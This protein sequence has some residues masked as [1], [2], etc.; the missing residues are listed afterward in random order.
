MRRA[1]PVWLV[2]IM[3]ATAAGANFCARDNVPSATLLFPFIAV[4]LDVAG[5]PDSTGETTISRVTNASHQA[6]V[7]HVTV[8]DVEGTPHAVF[9]EI[10]SGYDVLQINWR[11]FLNGRFDYF[12]TAHTDFTATLPWTLDPFEW[13]PDGRDDTSQSGSDPYGAG[14]PRSTVTASQCPMGPPYG[15]RSELAPVLR[16]LFAGSLAAR[17]HGGCGGLYSLRSTRLGLWESARTTPLVFYA[18]V[19]VVAGCT[20]LFPSQAAYFAG[21]ARNDNVL[22]GEVIYL[23]AQSGYS[24]MMPAVHIEAASGA[25]GGA[26]VTGFYEERTAGTETYREPLA[27]A[28]AFSY[29][30]DTAAGITSE[31]IVWKNHSEFAGEPDPVTGAQAICDLGSYVYYAWDMDERS[32][33]TRDLICDPGPCILYD[34]NQLPFITQRVPLVSNYFD[35][36]GAYGWMLL[37]F[38]PS[39]DQPFADRTP[40]PYGYLTHPTMGWAALRFEWGG[41]SC[42]SDAIT[43]SNALCFPTQ[44][45]PNL[46]TNDGTA[47]IR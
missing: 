13:G 3:V 9:N 43:M 28:L 29:A 5:V 4:D 14:E 25:T 7:V 36:P 40:E 42:G 35:L 8:W 41:Y 20:D 27:T 37:V 33:A 45:M 21:V 26:S 19:D 2:A 16:S 30:D 32:L 18:T 46:G 31:A 39:Y 17:E 12:D 1:A 15:N 10:L 22:F 44:V 24:E 6:V 34:P 11:D 23:D 47:P 38:P